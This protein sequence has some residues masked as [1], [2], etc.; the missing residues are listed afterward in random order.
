MVQAVVPQMRERGAGVIV[1]VTS[2]VTYK[3]LPLLSI[4]SASKAAVNAFS[5]SVALDWPR[6][7]SASISSCRA[8]PPTPA[9]ATM[10]AS[11]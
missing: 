2:S 9:S 7:A 6:S 8:A 5:D 10:R 11:A 1:N 3:P 4:Y